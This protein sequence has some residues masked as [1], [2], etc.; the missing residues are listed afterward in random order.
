MPFY[1][2]NSFQSQRNVFV[3]TLSLSLH[4]ISCGEDNNKIKIKI[5][6]FQSE[7]NN[8]KNKTEMLLKT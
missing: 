2:N 3:N 6:V 1:L 8:K 5:K 4:C 7:K